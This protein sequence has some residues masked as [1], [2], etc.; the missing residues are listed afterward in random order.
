MKF[1]NFEGE[2]TLLA[3]I[4]LC[5]LILNESLSVFCTFGLRKD[6]YI[7]IFGYNF[8]SKGNGQ[9][10]YGKMV[11]AKLKNFFAKLIFSLQI[12]FA[13]KDFFF[14]KYQKVL[15]GKNQLS[16]KGRSP[17]TNFH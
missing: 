6:Q 16:K 3:P 2:A 11:F 14:P 5:G 13:Q 4:G 7:S 1:V 17:R 9:P 8:S 10:Y 15:A 12:F